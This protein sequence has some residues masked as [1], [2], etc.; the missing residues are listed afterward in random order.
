MNA[1]SKAPPSPYLSSEDRLLGVLY[2]FVQLHESWSTDR[3]T[4]RAQIVQLEEQIQA[5]S[6][7]VGSFSELESSIR[8]Q[9]QSS[10]RNAGSQIAQVV[11]Q[12]TNLL[13][14]E[15]V[16]GQ[17]NRLSQVVRDAESILQDHRSQTRWQQWKMLGITLVV[18]VGVGVLVSWLFMPAP[19]IPLSDSQQTTLWHG[20]VYDAVWPKLPAEDQ[21]DW[22]QIENEIA[23][24]KH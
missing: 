10:I 22:K 14:T 20:Y 13:M 18:A 19:I 16:Y 15:A 23:R 6:G 7:E 3:Q 9:V 4:L 24:K 2:Q 11:K 21:E 8:E 5:L 12:E 1:S 17:V